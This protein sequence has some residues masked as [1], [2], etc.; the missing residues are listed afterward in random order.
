MLIIHSDSHSFF[1][2][3]LDDKD[4]EGEKAT[5]PSDPLNLPN[6]VPYLNNAPRGENNAAN[7]STAL[8]SHI[9]EDDVQM[10]ANFGESFLNGHG[11]PRMIDMKVI[12]PYKKVVTHGGYMHASADGRNVE[13]ST[14]AI[15]IFSA[16]YLPERTRKDYHYVMD[17]LFM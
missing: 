1:P 3:S 5:N 17:N 15:I 7:H 14:S 10:Q 9:P 12:E 6:D 11:E 2:L 8:P 4:E 16:C 13:G